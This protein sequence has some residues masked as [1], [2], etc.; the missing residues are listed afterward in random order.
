MLGTKSKTSEKGYNEKLVLIPTPALKHP[1][2]AVG[3]GV[4][5]GFFCFFFRDRKTRALL[6][7]RLMVTV[8]N[9]QN[10]ILFYT[11]LVSL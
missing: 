11:C 2:A 7:H 5:W 3:L 8:F 6:L 10:S 1:E 9:I 4:F